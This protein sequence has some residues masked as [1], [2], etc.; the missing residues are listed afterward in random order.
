[1]QLPSVDGALVK[2]FHIVGDTGGP[3]ISDDNNCNDDTRIVK[4]EFFPAKV[5]LENIVSSKIST[6]IKGAR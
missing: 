5:K 3:D 1:V 4:I 6:K 2:F